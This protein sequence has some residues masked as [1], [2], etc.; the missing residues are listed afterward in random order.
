MA[1][2]E[3]SVQLQLASRGFCTNATG[4]DVSTGETLVAAV[5]GKS[6]YIRSITIS[7]ISA[8]TVWIQDNTGT[9]VVIVGPIA[10]ADLTATSSVAAS[11]YTVTFLEPVKVASGNLIEVDA[12]AAG[13]VSVVI[14]GYTE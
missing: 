14:Q 8:I 4:S 5:A 6:H 3:T 11:P 12:S 13:A 1:A 2:L 10:F 7:C 9:P